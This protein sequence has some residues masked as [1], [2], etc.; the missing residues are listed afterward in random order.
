MDNRQ[1]SNW[2]PATKITKWSENTDEVA[3]WKTGR[4]TWIVK[5]FMGLGVGTGSEIDHNPTD[6]E[7]REVYGPEVNIVREYAVVSTKAA[8][9]IYQRAQ[10][11]SWIPNVNLILRT[12]QENKDA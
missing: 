1:T 8:E 7:I 11:A 2:K 5:E 12:M 6:E 4:N 10:E 9:M 3:V